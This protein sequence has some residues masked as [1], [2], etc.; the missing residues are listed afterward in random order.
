MKVIL[1]IIGVLLILMGGVWFFQGIN[2]L[3]GLHDG[4]DP[5]GDLRRDRGGLGYRPDPA[6]HKK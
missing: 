2:V 6:A 3:P 1:R 4:P 5:L